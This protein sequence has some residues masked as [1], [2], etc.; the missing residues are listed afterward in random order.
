MLK[1]VL[2]IH[3]VH[4]HLNGFYLIVG[5][6][7]FAGID[8]IDSEVV[9]DV[10]VPYLSEVDCLLTGSPIA[11]CYSENIAQLIAASVRHGEFFVEMLMSRHQGIY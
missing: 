9:D 8:F 2:L 4:Y 1:N 5:I 7:C 10:A 3:F 11:S 6:C